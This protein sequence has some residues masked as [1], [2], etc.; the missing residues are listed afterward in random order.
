MQPITPKV[1]LIWRYFYVLGAEVWSDSGLLTGKRED[2][3]KELSLES[4]MS[5]S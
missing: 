2:L 4:S 5:P 3:L 1:A